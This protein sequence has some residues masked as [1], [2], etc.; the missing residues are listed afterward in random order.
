M[1]I[2]HQAGEQPEGASLSHHQPAPPVVA[3][4]V[5]Y[6]AI[7]REL[8]RC[9]A[10]KE[11][12]G[13]AHS[14]AA[15]RTRR[16]A[17]ITARLDHPGIVSVHSL[18]ET[19]AG[20]PFYV[21][22][23]VAGPTLAHEIDRL[24]TGRSPATGPHIGESRAL[25][26]RFTSACQ[27]VAHAHHHGVAHLDLKPSNMILGPY[28]ET[29]VVDWGSARQFNRLADP[30]LSSGTPAYMSPEQAD[31]QLKRLDAR[32]DI[33]NLG[34]TL[35]H[36]LTGQ[37]PFGKPPS[38]RSEDETGDPSSL[39]DDSSDAERARLRASAGTFIAPRQIVPSID[40][41]LE[42][43]CLKAMAG[44]PE[45]RYPTVLSLVRD[46]ERWL[47]DEP[48]TVWRESLSNW[49]WRWMRRHRALAISTVV[50]L[51]LGFVGI[52]A[53]AL[54]LDRKN[55]ELDRQRAHAES[56]L[57]FFPEE[58]PGG[59]ASRRHLEGGLGKDVT[60]CGHSTPPNRVSRSLSL[61]NP[62][63]RRR[64]ATLGETYY[65]LGEPAVAFRQF[66]RAAELRRKGLG[67]D[68]PDTLESLDNI[69]HIHLDAG[70]I[71]EAMALLTE[72]LRRRKETLGADHD[73]TLDS[74]NN[75]AVAYQDDGQVAKAIPLLEEILK[76]RKD[77]HGLD[78][79]STLNSMNNLAS[80]SR[81]AGRF[82]DARLLFV[83][84]LDHRMARRGPTTRP[85]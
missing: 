41:A 59:G 18:G 83:E 38:S 48:V 16:E 47:A 9:V 67:P 29:V 19:S 75:L 51:S 56:L 74:L 32:T 11:I 52:A 55:R 24:H 6:L 54:V 78:H 7:D 69:A 58:G 71:D 77:K 5:V 68:H 35:Y 22:R 72:T 65:Y 45:E 42:A 10:L 15:E 57:E 50:V 12:A 62:W 31:H 49:S 43:V 37:A 36:I 46:V 27:A 28:G 80:A 85:R 21:M 14:L 39:E 61:T 1:P 44:M 82:E 53:F 76:R 13:D 30:A 63:W 3:L 84:V 34:A 66:E 2:A 60:L 20:R 17:E 8:R 79:P 81:D 25:L 26:D 4:G 23:F 73:D 70:R 40:K 33:F 64:F